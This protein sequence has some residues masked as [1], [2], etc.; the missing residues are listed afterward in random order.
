MFLKSYMDL[1]TCLVS[2]SLYRWFW[3]EN[4]H[5]LLCREQQS[6]KFRK[7]LCRGLIWPYDYML[8]HSFLDLFLQCWESFWT[9]NIM[10]SMAKKKIS[11]LRL[12]WTICYQNVWQ[13]HTVCMFI[14][15]GAVQN[16]FL[17]KKGVRNVFF[18][19]CTR[20]WYNWKE[21]RE[22]WHFPAALPKHPH[23][24]YLSIV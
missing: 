1:P 3:H 2:L 17:V 21:N 4:L 20:I 6:N 24:A 19:V 16:C 10:T 13:M 14:L 15:P 8:D 23:K 7:L 18:L 5:K 22:G 12:W 9:V 11:F